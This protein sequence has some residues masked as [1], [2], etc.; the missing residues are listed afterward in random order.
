[1]I[2]LSGRLTLLSYSMA[3]GD[4]SGGYGS[5]EQQ[6]IFS[7]ASIERGEFM[8]YAVCYI[9]KPVSESF[10][11]CLVG[12]SVGCNEGSSDVSSGVVFISTSVVAL[13][14]AQPYHQRH[15]TH[16]RGVT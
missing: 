15:V 9:G 8:S 2:T 11:S 16:G 12:W 3:K 14:L 5:L 7:L 4:S 10:Q 1:M 13:H 6:Y